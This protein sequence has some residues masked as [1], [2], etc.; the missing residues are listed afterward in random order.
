[1]QLYAIYRLEADLAY[2][3]C[4]GLISL[5]AARE[6]TP[7]ARRLCSMV[8]ENWRDLTDG[9][10]IPN[11]LLHAPIAGDWTKYNSVDNQGEVLGIDY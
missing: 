5:E 2:C 6:V 8:S 1:M 9:F 3:T 4:E 11:E 7:T 10:G